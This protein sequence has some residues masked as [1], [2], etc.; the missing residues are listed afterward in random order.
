M[1]KNV[2]DFYVKGPLYVSD[3]CYD[4]YL[5]E[6]VH[7]LPARHGLWN[8]Y[9]IGDPL[10]KTAF[11]IFACRQGFEKAMSEVFAIHT[12]SDPP[13]KFHNI[14]CESGFMGIFDE[15][16]YPMGVHETSYFES[17]C[18]KM[19]CVPV[20]IIN[21]R[22]CVFWVGFN[23][24]P[25]ELTVASDKKGKV[26]AIRLSIQVLTEEERKKIKSL[27]QVLSELGVSSYVDGL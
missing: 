26:Y 14:N 19:T 11:S 6:A 25:L 7:S 18:D 21:N 27:D 5:F 23:E 13:L 22:G 1:L 4:K 3:P 9:T 17:I 24:D 10:L 2:G 20:L 12:R 8:T 16:S 15:R